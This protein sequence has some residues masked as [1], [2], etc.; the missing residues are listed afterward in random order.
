[1]RPFSYERAADPQQALSAGARFL[2]GG[3]NLID[4]MKL[5]IETPERLVDVSRI[6][7]EI[8]ETEDGLAIGAGVTNSALAAH[9]LVR[10]R[11]PL[12]SAA[13]LAGA[14]Q[15]LRNKATTGGNFLQRTRCQYFYDT[16]RACNKRSPGSGCDA[17]D[18]F[19]RFH[20]ILGASENCIAVHPSDMAVAMVALDAAIHTIAADGSRLT[21][22]ADELLRLPGDTPHV[23]HRL[24]PGEL[25]VGVTLPPGPP[26]RQSYRKVRDRASYAFALV[27]LA[28]AADLDGGT[29]RNVR[30][31]LGGVAHKPWRASG[32]EEL[33][34]G[35]PASPGLFDEAAETAL[36]GAIGRGRNDYKIPL[37]RRLIRAGLRDLVGNGAGGE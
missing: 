34:E 37:A 4:L 31:V 21:L 32:A 15:Q 29:M 14:S 6:S 11:Y 30:I 13:I 27:S 19:N 23:E 33:L 20:A 22:A 25:I 24:E 3:T 7:R 5:E 26:A 17:L 35:K 18:G 12:L 1:M 8:E 9:P 28:L 16:A 10:E 2:G 36:E